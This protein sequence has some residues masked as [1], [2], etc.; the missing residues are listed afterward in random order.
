MKKLFALIL[1]LGLAGCATWNADVA[2]V[3]TAIVETITPDNFDSVTILMGTAES[4][5]YSY[6][7]L[8]ERRIINKACW[9]TIATLQPYEN[10]A[11]ISYI[12]LKK[13][14]RA[15]P[16]SDATTFIKA[17]KDAIVSLRNMQTSNGVN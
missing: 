9:K 5:G 17:A 8:C 14:V 12:T 4:A 16:T 3:K 7:D 15:N 2:K 1:A 11:Y 6:R 13:F 10:R